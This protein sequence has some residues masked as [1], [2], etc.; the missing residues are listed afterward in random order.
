MPPP[1]N[2]ILLTQLQPEAQS[3]A[4]V[5]GVLQG[6]REDKVGIYQNKK[7]KRVAGCRVCVSMEKGM[8]TH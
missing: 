2:E 1:E 4:S 5:C 6:I 8:G 7:K 3:E